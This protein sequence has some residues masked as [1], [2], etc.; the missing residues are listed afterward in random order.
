M[1][2]FNKEGEVVWHLTNE[3]LGGILN[4]VCGL[5]VLKSG[6]FVVT[7]Y[8]NQAKD[9]LKMIEITHDKKVVWSY[10]NPEVKYV[11]NL[12]VLST[13]GRAE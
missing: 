4:D 13:N 11:H 1:M 7:C 2:I 8:G 5:Q 3:E 6:N 12:H 10:Q 9:E